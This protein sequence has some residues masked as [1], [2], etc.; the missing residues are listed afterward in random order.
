MSD[1]SGEGKSAPQR[2]ARARIAATL[3]RVMVARRGLTRDDPGHPAPQDDSRER[4]TAWSA[5]MMMLT[6]SGGRPWRCPDGCSATRAA[7]PA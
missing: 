4:L 6:S 2:T 7:E 3:V 5:C 1:G